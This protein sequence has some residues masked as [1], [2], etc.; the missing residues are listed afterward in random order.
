MIKVI[1]WSFGFMALFSDEVLFADINNYERIK[2]KVDNLISE[3][4]YTDALDIAKEYKDELGGIDMGLTFFIINSCVRSGNNFNQ[5]N[6]SEDEY[7]G[8]VKLD[9]LTGSPDS[10]WTMYLAYKN[11]EFGLKPNKRISDC[12]KKSIESNNFSPSNCIVSK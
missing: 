8:M 5:C 12:W 10:G 11:G 1:V 9:A 6:I 7:I 4:R 2:F 3:N